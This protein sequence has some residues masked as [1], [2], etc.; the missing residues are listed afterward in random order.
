M[1]KINSVLVKTWAVAMVCSG[2]ATAATAQYQTYRAEKWDYSLGLKYSLASDISG[3]GGS[4][5]EV[6]EDLGFGFAAGYNFNDYFQLG[7]SFNWDSRGYRATGIG[8]DGSD[9]LYNNSMDTTVLGLNGIYFI[10]PGNL[11]PFVS[12]SMGYTFLDSNIQNGPPTTQCYYDPWWGHRCNTYT[13]TKT[14]SGMSYAVGIG[15]RFDLN[16]GASF[17]LSYNKA[18]L[19]ISSMSKTADFDSIRIDF[20][21]R[22]F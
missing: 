18:W 22:T 19:D 11:T 12:G 21:G 17:Q 14:K 3:E 4:K 5:A 1:F 9:I 8:E 6:D 2:I 20:I 7:G 16:E 10:L 15:L 13:P